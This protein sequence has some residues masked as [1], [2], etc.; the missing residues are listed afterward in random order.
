[1]SAYIN[2]LGP[3]WRRLRLRLGKEKA[4]FA[5]WDVCLWGW[6]FLFTPLFLL[7]RIEGN[8][9]AWF[10]K[11]C[12]GQEPVRA[13]LF[14]FGTPPHS[15]KSGLSGPPAQVSNPRPGAPGRYEQFHEF[16]LISRLSELNSDA[17]EPQRVS[18]R[19][20][21]GTA[22]AGTL[23][24]IVTRHVRLSKNYGGGHTVAKWR[25]IH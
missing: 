13:D 25:E 21:A 22:L 24:Y 11:Y 10:G 19:R 7:Y 5:A 14:L 9:N 20:W 3:S 18:R 4:A 1:M 15:S 6:S 2:N 12:C 8:S 23:A 16:R 17:W